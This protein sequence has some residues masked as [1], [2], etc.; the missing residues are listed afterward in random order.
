MAKIIGYSIGDPPAEVDASPEITEALFVQVGSTFRLV[1]C[2][3]SREEAMGRMEYL[4][5]ATQGR[6]ES[7][8]GQY[9]A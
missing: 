6:D 9:G 1:A 4:A 3:K 8:L 5:F 7:I 2:F